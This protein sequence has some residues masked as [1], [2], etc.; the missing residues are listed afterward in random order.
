MARM[1]KV[2]RSLRI[3][4]DTDAAVGELRTAEETM[5]DAVNRVL[6]VGVETLREA[7]R[8][9][10]AQEPEPERDALVTALERHINTLEA[11]LEV[12]DGQIADLSSS[13]RAAQ[14]LHAADKQPIGIEAHTGAQTAPD[15]PQDA[16]Q[17]EHAAQDVP[18]GF[19]AR[20]KWAM[21]R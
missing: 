16:P 9:D 11:Q 3:D 5:T 20:I 6:R 4:A 17:G 1:A 12:K 19:W 2:H 7:G 15:G 14:T 8:K 13:L 10:E 18:T 21:S